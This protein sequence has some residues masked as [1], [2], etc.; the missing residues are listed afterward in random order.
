MIAQFLF[1]SGVTILV[2][3]G[4]IFVKGALDDVAMGTKPST[5]EKI[6]IWALS[7]ALVAIPTAVIINFYAQ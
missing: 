1:A 3:V 7:Y 6:V 4:I 2:L 5:Y